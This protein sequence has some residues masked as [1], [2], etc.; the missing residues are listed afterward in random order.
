MVS[1]WNPYFTALAGV[2][3]ALTGLVF[4]AL[5][6]NLKEILAL[7]G[8]TGRALEAIVLLVTPVLVGLTGL[9]PKQA[10]STLGVELLIFGVAEW[11]AVNAIVVAGREALSQRPRPELT[12]RIILA[13]VA[14]LLTVTAALLLASGRIGGLYWLA[15]ARGL[16]LV[17]GVLDAWVLL[18]EILR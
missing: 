10:A 13:E 6:I 14:T 1:Q 8:V 16:S 2:F 17:V 3:A 15:A 9:L 18:V 12:M 5:S 11:L 4:V 7:P